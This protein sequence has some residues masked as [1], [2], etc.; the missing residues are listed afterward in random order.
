MLVFRN[1]V[2]ADKKSLLAIQQQSEFNHWSEKQ[3]AQSLI[4]HRVY[5]MVNK[6]NSQ[7]ILG[8]AIFS[9]II[10]EAELLNI[11]IDKD[12]QGKGL[13]RKLL[14]YSLLNLDGIKACFLEVAANNQIAIKLYSSLNF[15]Q[16]G[17]RK[18]YYRS[19]ENA[20]DAIIMK[21]SL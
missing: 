13:G 6:N 7:R 18:N 1:A 21:R 16:I 2:A 12:D 11:V 9:L 15:R 19:G 8:F 5:L 17:L 14:E 3:I 4:D 10:D 20:T